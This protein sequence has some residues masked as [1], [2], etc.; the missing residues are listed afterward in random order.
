MSIISDLGDEFLQFF[1]VVPEYTNKFAPGISRLTVQETLGLS[2]ESLPEDFFLL[3]EWRNGYIDFCGDPRFNLASFAPFHFNSIETVVE[4][5]Q[6]S[7][8]DG[9]NPRYKQ[10]EVLPFVSGDGL[11][12]GIVLDRDYNK[13]PH[14]VYFS[15]MGDCVL[16]YD[17]ITTMLKTI[18][19]SFRVGALYFDGDLIEKNNQLFSEVLSRNNPKVIAEVISGFEDNITSYGTDTDLDDEAYAIKCSSLWAALISL[20]Y[21]PTPH[22]IKRCQIR[23]AELQ[24]LSSSRAIGARE[25]LARWIWTWENG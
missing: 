20:Q 18:V 25:S 10:S 5:N 1:R 9:D 23:I 13:Q 11:F 7:W 19:E 2:E 14:V 17:S 21:M 6:W 15:T 22:M 4:E 12:W 8:C 16:T 3:Y 24:G